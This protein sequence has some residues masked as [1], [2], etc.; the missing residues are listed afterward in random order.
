MSGASAERFHIPDRGIL[1]ENKA[2]DILVFD[3]E[4]IKD[5]NTD[6][7]TSETPSGI[8]YVFINGTLALDQGAINAKDKP[9]VVI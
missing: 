5:N 6:I 1:A 9:G 2:A 3:W 8:D 7:K 4:N